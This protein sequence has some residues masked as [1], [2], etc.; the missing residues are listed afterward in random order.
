MITKE[1]MQ[2]MLDD[3]IDWARQ[4][5]GTDKD[6]AV[7]RY[8]SAFAD[9]DLFEREAR[10]KLNNEGFHIHKGKIDGI[11]VKREGRYLIL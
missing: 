11:V 2:K 8:L 6:G 10:E 3:D 5:S 7:I 1:E 9:D 4:N